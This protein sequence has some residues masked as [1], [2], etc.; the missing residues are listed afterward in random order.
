MNVTIK[1][2]FKCKFRMGQHSTTGH[3]SNKAGTGHGKKVFPGV[4]VLVTHHY[5]R[6]GEW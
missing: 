4:K 5:G 2:Q 6:L 1:L 3:T